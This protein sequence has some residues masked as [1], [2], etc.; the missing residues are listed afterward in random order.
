MQIMLNEAEVTQAVVSHLSN[1]GLSISGE[2]NVEFSMTRNPSTIRA[3]VT[4]NESA[5]ATAHAA[6]NVPFESD[7]VQDSEDDEGDDLF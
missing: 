5:V 7:S 2:V 4:F 3:E 1:Q 6:E